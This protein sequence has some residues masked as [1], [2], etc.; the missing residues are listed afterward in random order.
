[1][2]NEIENQGKTLI[3]AGERKKQ[4]KEERREELN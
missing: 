2:N 3:K 4:T 1:V